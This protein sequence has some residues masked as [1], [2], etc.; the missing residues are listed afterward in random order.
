MPIPPKARPS[1]S[2]TDVKKKD[3]VDMTNDEGEPLDKEDSSD[4]DYEEHTQR[5]KSV[6][7]RSKLQRR[8][9]DLENW[10]KEALITKY[11]LLQDD[12][13]EVKKKR[14]EDR[15]DR[16]AEKKQRVQLQ[17][18]IRRLTDDMEKLRK[19]C[20][21][22]RLR[23]FEKEDM[24][25]A[26]LEEKKEQFAEAQEDWI[27]KIDESTYPALP[28]NILRDQ[29]Q[30]LLVRCKDWVRQWCMD[31]TSPESLLFFCKIITQC[32][33][34]QRISAERIMLNKMASKD[35]TMLRA[36]GFAWLA[37]EMMQNF[38]ESPFLASENARHSLQRFYDGRKGEFCR[39]YSDSADRPR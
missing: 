30:G 17:K 26:A 21:E 20:R 31:Q 37:R 15:K 11:I 8:R 10:S 13:A 3:I 5:S 39:L 34:N 4:T 2:A 18:D 25:R 14:A 27:A 32:A 28:D 24:F 35:M 23:N 16:D 7:A 33:S 29:F 12:R 6:T 9:S 1:K 22:L 36:A 38:F 19:E